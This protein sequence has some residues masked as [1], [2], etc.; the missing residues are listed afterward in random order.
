MKKKFLCLTAAAVLLAQQS[1]MALGATNPSSTAAPAI[2]HERN[3]SN[4]TSKPLDLS[5][6]GINGSATNQAGSSN[7]GITVSGSNVRFASDKEVKDNLPAY[8]AEDVFTIN[9]GTTALYRVIGTPDL[10]GYNPLIPV[11][12]VVAD[13]ATDTLSFSVYVPN[14]VAGLT[15]VEILYF[16]IDTKQWERT[17]PTVDFS[18]KTVSVALKSGTPFTVIYK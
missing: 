3:D 8:A 2:S 12:T 1:I 15:N 16:N 7:Y 13:G 6:L 5:G 9:S 14:L 10:V 11:Q 4:A 18:S 17:V